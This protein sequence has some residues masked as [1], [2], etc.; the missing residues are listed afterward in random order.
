VAKREAAN[1]HD[2]QS[3]VEFLRG[4]PLLAGVADADFAAL[5]PHIQ[6]RQYQKGDFVYLQG[7]PADFLFFVCRGRVKVTQTSADGKQVILGFHGPNELVG[8]CGILGDVTFPCCARATEASDLIRVGRQG[9]LDLLSRVPPAAAVL[10]S[11]VRRLREAH[12]RMRQLALEPVEQRIVAVLLDVGEKFGHRKNGVLC[13]PSKLTR[14]QIAELAG[15]TLETA[16][17]VL[18]KLR[19]AGLVRCSRRDIILVDPERLGKKYQERS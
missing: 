3:T 6:S 13:L 5:R 15:A 17:R 7:Q 16:S 11:F 9:F 19:R 2:W 4:V 1:V 10:Q 8:C 18:S 14:Q 12:Q